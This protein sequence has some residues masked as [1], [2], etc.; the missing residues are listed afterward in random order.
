MI[1]FVL[2]AVAIAATI[3]IV[4]LISG[5]S[6]EW[7]KLGIIVGIFTPWIT[8]DWINIWEAFRKRGVVEGLGYWF[9][10]TW[11]HIPISLFL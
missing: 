9:G 3:W 7:Y 4:Q 10:M 11:I 1:R 8:T 2:V 6:L 5:K